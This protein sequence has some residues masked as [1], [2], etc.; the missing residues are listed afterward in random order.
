MGCRRDEKCTGFRAFDG[1]SRGGERER[2]ELLLLGP[3]DPGGAD[4]EGLLDVVMWGFP[5]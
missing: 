3:Q 1:Q 4:W 2:W 5:W